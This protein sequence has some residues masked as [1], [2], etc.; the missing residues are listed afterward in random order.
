M[1]SIHNRIALLFGYQPFPI[2]VSARMNIGRVYEPDSE[3]A[4]SLDHVRVMTLR[5][6]KEL[7]KIHKFEISEVKGSCVMLPENMRFKGFIKAVDRFFSKFPS[8]AYRSVVVC[9][10]KGT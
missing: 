4:Q 1:A 3:H 5:S 6:L 2:G 9:R 10:K 7:L 8:L